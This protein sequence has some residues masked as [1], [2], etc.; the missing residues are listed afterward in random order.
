MRNDKT[1]RRRHS[2]HYSMK[3]LSS[4][5]GNTW[6]FPEGEMSFSASQRRSDLVSAKIQQC[7][8]R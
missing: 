4:C 7:M 6:Y 5:C 1:K 3:L 2:S 8:Q